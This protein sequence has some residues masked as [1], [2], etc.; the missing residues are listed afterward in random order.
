MLDEKIFHQD[1]MGCTTSYSM[2]TIRR[3]Y[4]LAFIALTASYRLSGGETAPL[5]TIHE[6]TTTKEILPFV[7][8]LALDIRVPRAA[9]SREHLGE[10]TILNKKVRG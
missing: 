4:I 7:S 1:C 8:V 10:K 3:S 9:E 5:I 2:Q 6:K